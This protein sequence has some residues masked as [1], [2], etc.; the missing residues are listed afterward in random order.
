MIRVETSKGHTDEVD[1]VVACESHGKGECT[2]EHDKLE[3]IHLEQMDYLHDN[4]RTYECVNNQGC[5]VVL[6][7]HSCALSYKRRLA[8]AL[9]EDEVRKGCEGDTAENGY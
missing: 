9:E 5:H 1:K 8:Q 7:P 2:H 3:H 6:N 4:G